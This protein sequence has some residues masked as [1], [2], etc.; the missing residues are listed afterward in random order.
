M[1]WVWL[2]VVVVSSSL[3]QVE[4]SDSP[5]SGALV[6][7]PMLTSDY[8]AVW[9][10]PANLGFVPTTVTFTLG[11]PMEYGSYR[12]A[13]H[14][15]IG[16]GEVGASIESNALNLGELASMVFR[17][18]Q[19]RFSMDDKRRIASDFAGRGIA[20][21]LDAQIIGVAYQSSS[22]G[23]IAIGVRDRLSAEF[24]L[25][26][27]LARIAFLGR[28][29]AYF[30]STALN[31]RG[32]TV[33]YARHPKYYSEL[34]DSSRIA[35]SWLRDF[36]IGYGVRIYSGRTLQ[37]YGG[38]TARLIEGYALLDGRIENRT[39]TAYSAIS[40]YFGVS[41]GKATT[42]SL[43]P[44]N[45]LV[46][47]GSG[48]GTDL[49]ITATIGERWSTAIAVLDIGSVWWDGNVFAVQD[50]VLNGLITTGLSSYDIF[51]EA[52]N[53][54][55]EGGYFKWAGLP[56]IRTMLPTRLRL[57]TCYAIGI[58]RNIGIELTIPLRPNAPGASPF[59]ATIG[60]RYSLSAQVVVSGGVRIGTVAEWAVPLSVQ[61][62]LWNGRWEIGASAQDIASLVFGKHPVLSLA[63]AVVRFRF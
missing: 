59:F 47:V 10:N 48:F 52:Q 13:R 23:G 9:V 57:G 54:T 40:P 30:D 63:L 51:S 24:Q 3:A 29:D 45:G 7:A 11:S 43:R 53:I 61:V 41:Y 22:W 12:I 46:P 55:G 21:N 49:G 62:S 15:S 38:F 18:D 5:R 28:L 34:F 17:F 58:E 6:L 44:G 31:W 60:T 50:T 27:M 26:S 37:L 35:M 4:L 33:G 25:N 39:I 56:G 1:R 16:V 8:R 2:G 20:F 32:D 14:W 42:P 19:Q 36:A